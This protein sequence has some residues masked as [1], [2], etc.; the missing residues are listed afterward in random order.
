R[1]NAEIS[2]TFK[3]LEKIWDEYEVYEKFD[4]E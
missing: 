3:R 1:K 2:D 4:N